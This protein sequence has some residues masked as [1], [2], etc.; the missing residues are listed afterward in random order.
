MNRNIWGDFQIC[1]SVP[2]TTHLC[3]S[4]CVSKKLFNIFMMLSP[5]MNAVS[6]EVGHNEASLILLSVILL[7]LL[8]FSLLL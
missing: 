8:L 2:L 1:I 7:L 4:F 6:F 5:T 3:Y